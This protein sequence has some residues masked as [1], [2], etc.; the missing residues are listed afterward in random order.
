[1]ATYQKSEAFVEHLMD[2]VHDLF[3][4]NPGTDCDTGQIY[5]SNV[6][7][8]PATHLV[9][10]DLAEITQENGYT[11]PIAIT[12]NGT[13]SGGTAT[14]NG[15]SQSITASG[16]TIGPYRTMAVINDT[17][18]SPADPIICAWDRGASLTLQDGESYEMRFNNATVG[19]RGTIFTMT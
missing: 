4:T 12:N 2:Q 15:L 9:K 8:A 17:P 5:L 11:G 18:T 3:G 13:R 14:F 10:A 7:Y 1:M 16:G 19:N 6:A